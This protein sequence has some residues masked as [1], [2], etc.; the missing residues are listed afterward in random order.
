MVGAVVESV[1][2]VGEAM[3]AAGGAVVV[4][5]EAVGAVGEVVG[6][7]DGVVGASSDAMG[8]VGEM[9]RVRR[10]RSISPGP[11]VAARAQ[12]SFTPRPNRRH[13]RTHPWIIPPDIW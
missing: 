1:A 3:G 11:G 5:G 12:G 6:A 13:T 2:A 8:A 4:F 10:I 7:V 9:A